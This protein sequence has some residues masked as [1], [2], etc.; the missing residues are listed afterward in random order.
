MERGGGAGAS[1]R[2]PRALVLDILPPVAE[3][4]LGILF[5]AFEPSGDALAAP[6]I[7]A[8]KER[9]PDLRIFAVGGPR[10]ESAGAEM[11]ERTGNDGAM[12]LGAIGKV[13]AVRGIVSRLRRWSKQYRVV[14]HV[15]VDSPAAN[16]PIAKIMQ[17]AGARVVHLA[18]PQIWAWAPWRIGKLRRVTSMVLCLL[19]FEKRWFTERK[20]PARFIGHPVLNRPLDETE[21]A[22]RAATLPRGGPKILLLPGSR[23][24]EV[25]NNVRMLHNV[26]VELQGRHS[27][28]A[29]L[30]VA[31]S[32]AIAER[33]RRRIKVFPTGLHLATGGPDADGRLV[34]ES[35]IRWCDLAI[36]VSGTVTLDLARQRR[37]MIGVYRTGVI[38][39]LGAKVL[40]T[41]RHRLLPNIIAGREICPEFVPHVGG[42]GPVVEA[43]AEILRDSKRL[44]QQSEEL[45]RIV[46]A[47][48]GRDPAEEAVNAILDVIGEAKKTEA[49]VATSNGE[50]GRGAAGRRQT[51]RGG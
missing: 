51:A 1:P 19:P 20:V 30:M 38:S 26:F 16:F 50:Q 37:P 29:G 10:M 28:A 35:A 9:R 43:A 39:W 36:A 2:A 44:A 31:A 3:P 33:V 24:A 4:S 32:P 23:S 15:P 40:L 21:I 11:V 7:A 18:A 34:L 8:L 17:A 27:S 48:E 49:P 47:Y 12:G 13:F 22:Q 45:A 14:C 46:K 6:V 25:D 5:T 42:A 41:T